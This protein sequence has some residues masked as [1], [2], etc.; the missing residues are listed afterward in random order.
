M[1][2]SPPTTDLVVGRTKSAL[3]PRVVKHLNLKRKV[4]VKILEH[5]YQHRQLDAQGLGGARWAGD[6][7]GGD[8]WAGQVEH[9]A[10]YF[11]IHDPSQGP[12]LDCDWRTIA[13]ACV[14]TGS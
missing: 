8:V 3:D 12:I 10:L 4:L 13:D 9:A 5:Q 6:E 1:L 14:R 2:L 7:G 11:F